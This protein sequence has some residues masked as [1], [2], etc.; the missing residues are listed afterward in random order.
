MSASGEE[1]TIRARGRRGTWR[2]GRGSWQSSEPADY[3]MHENHRPGLVHLGALGT[4]CGAD[5]DCRTGASVA[6]KIDFENMSWSS[7]TDR[8]C[9]PHGFSIVVTLRS[10]PG[11][12]ADLKT[13]QEVDAGKFPRGSLRSRDDPAC[14]VASATGEVNANA[15]AGAV[16]GD[17]PFL[18]SLA[19]CGP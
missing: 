11:N 12:R 14:S 7:I 5:H 13:T 6:Q 16:D 19:R 10:Y 18:D 9:N 3:K 15:D 1:G 17:R 4:L 8:R 2:S